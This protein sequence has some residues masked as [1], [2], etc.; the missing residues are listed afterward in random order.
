M[1]GLQW[2]L[3][4]FSR[5]PGAGVPKIAQ[6]Y[7]SRDGRFAPLKD[8]AI[9][10]VCSVGRKKHRGA[11]KQPESRTRGITY[12]T[13]QSPGHRHDLLRGQR[14]S[15][16]PDTKRFGTR[17]KL[18]PHPT[19]SDFATS[20]HHRSHLGVRGGR[21]LFCETRSSSAQNVFVFTSSPPAGLGT[22]SSAA[23]APRRPILPPSTPLCPGAASTW[24]ST[25]GRPSNRKVRPEEDRMASHAEE[26]IR[27][28]AEGRIR[29]DAKG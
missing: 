3:Q 28:E 1:S 15:L 16:S 11:R 24:I 23:A 4:M 22:P 21:R 27:G 13:N 8:A 29:R 25:P 5:Y 17:I 19:A 18:E 14:L 20:R 6:N 2:R 12:H 9:C 7:W 26:S 10:R